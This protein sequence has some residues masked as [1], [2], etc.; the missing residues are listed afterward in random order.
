MLLLHYDFTEATLN[1]HKTKEGQGLQSTLGHSENA[2]SHSK[3]T[4]AVLLVV[5]GLFE[6][7][8]D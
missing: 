2:A 8:W 1:L 3:R 6:L 4:D 5:T 7:F